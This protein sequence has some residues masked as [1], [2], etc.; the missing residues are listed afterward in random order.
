MALGIQVDQLLEVD[1]QSPEER[2]ASFNHYISASNAASLRSKIAP[3]V[4]G[5]PRHSSAVL[6]VQ[7]GDGTCRQVRIPR[8]ALWSPENTGPATG[9][10]LRLHRPYPPHASRSGR[11]V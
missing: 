6:T 1:G 3:L 9:R 7:N 4:L 2:L 8:G 10:P 5:G 11:R